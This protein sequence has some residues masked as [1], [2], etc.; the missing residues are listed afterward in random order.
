[1]PMEIVIFDGQLPMGDSKNATMVFAQ[2]FRV[3]ECVL[4]ERK[5][6]VTCEGVQILGEE[7]H[8]EISSHP[9]Y[10][11]RVLVGR[12][13]GDRAEFT[14]LPPVD[15]GLHRISIEVSPFP[16]S[17]LCDDFTLQRVVFSAE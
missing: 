10:F 3:P 5:L 15:A 11:D 4:T 16:G 7:R 6:T 9:V 13:S 14:T 8:R 1:M 12:V 2:D 17:G